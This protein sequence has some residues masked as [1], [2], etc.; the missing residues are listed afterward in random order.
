VLVFNYRLAVTMETGVV[1]SGDFIQHEVIG[2]IDGPWVTITDMLAH[3]VPGQDTPV[4]IIADDKNNELMAFDL[5]S[6]RCVSQC[7]TPAIPRCLYESEGDV[8]LH[9][10]DGSLYKI[11]SVRPLTISTSPHG[12]AEWDYYCISN[13]GSGRLVAVSP[14]PPAVH[15]IDLHGRLLADLATCGGYSFIVARGVVCGGGRV[16]VSGTGRGRCLGRE[17]EIEERVVCMEESA[18][19][20]SARWMHDVVDGNTLTPIITP[21]GGNVIVPCESEFGCPCSIVSL[22]METGAVLQQ[23]D[24][25]PGCPTLGIA[26]CVYGGCLLVGC[27]DGVVV[28]FSLLGMMVCHH[29]VVDGFVEVVIRISSFRTKSYC[30]YWFFFLLLSS[31]FEIAPQV[32][33]IDLSTGYNSKSSPIFLT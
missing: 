23:V 31:N 27:G 13:L 21:G 17:W 33:P 12:H 2:S 9:C 16:V 20:W 11:S 6:W 19:A 5:I 28:E 7:T 30:F 3:T 25:A 32:S 29:V 14:F 22:S 10:D 4:I 26:T 8:S 18:G 1:S 15:V 24:V